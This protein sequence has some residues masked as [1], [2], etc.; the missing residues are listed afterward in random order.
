MNTTKI[1]SVSLVNVRSIER[2]SFEMR[3][4]LNLIIGDNGVGKSTL[5]MSID[6]VIHGGYN[7]ALVRKGAKKAEIVLALSNGFKVKKTIYPEGSK[8]KYQL[9]VTDA[10][11]ADVSAPQSWIN[12]IVDTISVDPIE[13]LSKKPADRGAAI[14]DAMPMRVSYEELTEA[15]G[16]SIS[17]PEG[18]ERGHGL[19]V[20]AQVRSMVFDARTNY[21]RNR[22]RAEA[23]ADQL[24]ETLDSESGDDDRDYER[25]IAKKKESLEGCKAEYDKRTAAIRKDAEELE[26]ELREEYERRLEGI[27]KLRDAK[28]EEEREEYGDLTDDLKADVADL[29]NRSKVATK[30]SAARKLIESYEKETED[31]R[32][33]SD[34]CS[35]AI[36][37]LDG[38]KLDLMAGAP[39]AGFEILDNGDVAIDGIPLPE[40]NT[41]KQ[42]FALL[43]I[44]AL[45]SNALPVILYDRIESLVGEQLD[46]FL[47]L[48]EADD[49]IQVIAAQAVNGAK[50]S[51]R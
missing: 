30:D 19:A 17:V 37:R 28:L 42:Y 43:K 44:A 7:P 29:E 46:E 50:L 18:M 51:V 6:D 36:E 4:G 31:T 16:G 11:G 34:S 33:R 26:D 14:L 27:R 49:T 9:T 13:L 5:L 38:L 21:N 8:S 35:E 25:E 24:R 3:A 45:R 10:T 40:L 22:K 39:L 1:D 41:A 15:V 48:C 23:A 47:A 20:I 2:A 12:D 32:E